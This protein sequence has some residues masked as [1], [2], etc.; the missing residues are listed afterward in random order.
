MGRAAKRIVASGTPILMLT[1]AGHPADSR[2]AYAPSISG[3][4]TPDHPCAR[5]RVSLLYSGL[6]LG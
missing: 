3:A 4:R 2:C 6:F 5:L 1:A